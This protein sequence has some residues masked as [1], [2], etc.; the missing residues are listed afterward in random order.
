MTLSSQGSEVGADSTL[1][2]KEIDLHTVLPCFLREYTL[3]SETHPEAG[4]ALDAHFFL[5]R[6]VSLLSAV[7]LQHENVW[8][9]GRARTVGEVG[10]KVPTVRILINANNKV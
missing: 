7:H 9:A 8:G 5:E 4:E 10:G 6:F 1:P 3:C 2:K